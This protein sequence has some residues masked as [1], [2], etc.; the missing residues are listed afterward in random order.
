MSI[1]SCSSLEYRTSFCTWHVE[2]MSF[3][4]TPM[5]DIVL[6]TLHHA[7]MMLWRGRPLPS[8][9]TPVRAYRNQV[10]PPWVRS[11]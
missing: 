3:V 8:E 5:T 6:M 4:T 9:V 1:W 10:M 7:E 11:C 2:L